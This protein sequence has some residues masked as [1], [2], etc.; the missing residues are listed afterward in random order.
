MKKQFGKVLL[1][2]LG[3]GILTAVLSF[4]TS[5]PA[6]AQ[7]PHA[8]GGPA[9]TVANTP[10]PVTGSVGVTNSASSPVLV[11]DVD[12]PGRHPFQA[13]NGCHMSSGIDDICAFTFSVPSTNLLVIETVSARVELPIGQKAV[14]R[15]TTTQGGVGVDHFLTVDP[16]GTFGTSD[17]LGVTHSVR[18][19]ADP[20][21]TVRVRAARPS[22]TGGDA[23]VTG[24]I[25]GYLVDCGAGSGCPL[26]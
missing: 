4:V 19:Y 26:P 5:G 23:D 18:L 9:V 22:S 17:R 20:G 2:A 10:L 7:N 16:Q 15:I 3:F 1:L 6:G 21:T 12:N 11:R 24:A 8:P 14:V 25:S 13:V